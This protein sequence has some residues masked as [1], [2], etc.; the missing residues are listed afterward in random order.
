MAYDT[1]DRSF[2]EWSSAPVTTVGNPYYNVVARTDDSPGVGGNSSDSISL[3]GSE[4]GAGGG[5]QKTSPAA[6]PVVVSSFNMTMPKA[7]TVVSS[8]GASSGGMVTSLVGS[9]VL[10]TPPTVA[11]ADLRPLFIRPSSLSDD[12]NANNGPAS[13][14]STASAVGIVAPWQLQDF[15]EG[16]AFDGSLSGLSDLAGPAY[17]K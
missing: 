5:S 9:S 8:V 7:V 2:R 1:F 11:A 6:T 13:I 15:G 17:V 14:T 4:Q 16:L 12:Q 10:Q 3:S